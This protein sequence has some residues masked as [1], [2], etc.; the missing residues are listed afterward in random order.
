MIEVAFST[1]D[2]PPLIP[3]S[4]YALGRN[5]AEHA[6]EMEADPE[7]VVFIMPRTALRP[8]GGRI[9]RP[10]GCSLV[11]HE[12]EVVLALGIGGSRL[13]AREA[14]DAIAGL[15]IGVDLTARDI[16]AR[17]KEKRHPWARSKGFAGA[18]PI[19]A[20]AP[21]APW[22]RRWKEIDLHLS[23]CGTRRQSGTLGQA[24][25]SP[26]E[27]VMQLSRWFELEAGDLIFTGTPAGVGPIQ[28][29]EPCVAKSL[30]LGM[31]VA[32]EL[33]VP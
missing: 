7:P 30:A 8:G 19:S 26:V 11:H 1:G 33:W 4:I 2:R 23:V 28:P 5:Y 16:Q 9:R 22:K 10:E 12:V 14:D 25:L 24:I 20:L 3:A 32:F 18:A 31:E 15:A 6:R 29:G 13:S 17:A 27:T 21:W